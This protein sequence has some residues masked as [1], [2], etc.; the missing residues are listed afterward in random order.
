[1]NDT[2]RV[3]PLTTQ[4]SRDALL[5]RVNQKLPDYEAVGWV[6]Y[7]EPSRADL[8][9]LIKRGTSDWSYVYLNQYTGELL[10]D[11]LPHDHFFTDWLLELHFNLLLHD[12]GM[13]LTTILGI[14][15]LF[16]GIT[17]LVLHRKFWK[18]FFT[19]RW[20][21]RLVVYFSDLHKMIGVVSAPILLLLSFTGVWW[22]IASLLHEVEAH[23]D[24]EEH[25]IMDRRLY[26][27]DV[28]LES[29][30][31][32][33]QEE[34]PGFRAT[35]LTMPWEPGVDFSVWGDVP[36]DSV[37][38]SEYA[39]VVT[40]DAWSGDRI[41]SF[42]IREAS[43]GAVIVDSYRRLH[44]GDFAGLTSKVIWCVIGLMPLLLSVTGVT[45]WWKRRSKRVAKRLN[46]VLET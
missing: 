4:Q 46:V 25:H 7:L 10:S 11:P 40:F 12:A 43:T 28:S 41:S 31:K 38:T 2:V 29:L 26:S 15:L 6:W 8:M 34:I 42:D 3:S 36:N 18:S 1:M 17:G 13:L 45:L 9:Y 33:A 32:Q 37:F 21:S 35:Y 39:S 14:F 23:S 5:A 16:L 24:G 22:N 30:V 19:L 27:N 20:N 44:F